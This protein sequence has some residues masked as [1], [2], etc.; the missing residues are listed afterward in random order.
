M[1]HWDIGGLLM[2]GVIKND[3]GQESVSAGV[4][5]RIEAQKL[6]LEYFYL[7]LYGKKIAQWHKTT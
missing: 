6:E 2:D 5:M 4:M 7:A 3:S 1:Q